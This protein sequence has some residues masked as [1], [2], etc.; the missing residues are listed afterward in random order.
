MSKKY[1]FVLTLFDGME[2]YSDEEIEGHVS[3]PN[4][5]HAEPVRYKG[6]FDSYD[7]AK[8]YASNFKIYKYIIDC[9]AGYG[10][11]GYDFNCDS[12]DSDYYFISI[13]DAEDEACRDLGIEPGDYVYP[14]PDSYSVTEVEIDGEIS[15]AYNYH[16]NKEVVFDSSESEYYDTYE[17]AEEAAN[18]YIDEF[19]I[20]EEGIVPFTLETIDIID[21][22]IEEIEYTED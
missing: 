14:H 19:E 11:Y 7:E 5:S 8:Q 1:I 18:S 13:Y 3:W 20:T 17:E 16:F 15:F 10:S 22:R 4:Y 6:I 9:P 21:I 12:Y 2:I